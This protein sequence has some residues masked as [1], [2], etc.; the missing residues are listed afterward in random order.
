MEHLSSLVSPQYDAISWCCHTSS[1]LWMLLVLAIYA[2][3]SGREFW[4][5][6]CLLDLS[7][8]KK[9]LFTSSY[10]LAGI[11]IYFNLVAWMFFRGEWCIRRRMEKPYKKNGEACPS[12][13]N[14]WRAPS[15]MG[16]LFKH[17]KYLKYYWQKWWM[18]LNI[19]RLFSKSNE[20]YHDKNIES[21]M[22]LTL[23]FWSLFSPNHGGF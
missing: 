13:E 18:D 8:W 7:S 11:L 1:N 17:C 5:V 20:I 9:A 21:Q 23:P 3:R 22:L 6:T 12:W 15:R 19:R 10:S 2:R 14:V 16:G 4:P